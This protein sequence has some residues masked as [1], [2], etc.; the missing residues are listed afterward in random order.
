MSL[1]PMNGQGSYQSAAD[2]IKRMRL[3]ADLLRKQ[4]METPQG[5]M[6]GS[7]GGGTK[8]FGQQPEFYVAPHW[9]EQLAPLA[10]AG[11]SIWGNRQADTA[12]TA[13]DAQAKQEAD[14]AYQ[15]F[16]TMQ[17]QRMALPRTLG[18]GQAGPERSPTMLATRPE[19]GDVQGVQED[20]TKSQPEFQ[21][22][23][24]KYSANLPNGNP[25]LGDLKEKL[26]TKSLEMAGAEYKQQS[27]ES[28]VGQRLAH[29]AST[30]DPAA[31]KRYQYY[32]RLSP[33]Q[34][35]DFDAAN[36]KPEWLNQGNQVQQV[37]RAG[38]VA[39]VAPLPVNL[40]PGEL[41]Q[42]KYLQEKAVNQAQVED[43]AAAQLP[44]LEMKMGALADSNAVFNDAVDLAKQQ[45]EGFGA[46]GVGSQ[47]TK[48][49]GGTPAHNLSQTIKTIEAS[50]GFSALQQ[51]KD[52]S[53]QG[54]AL[55]QVSD[56]E[57]IYLKTLVASV[58]QSQTKEQFLKNLD[59]LKAAKANQAARMRENY[60]R[61]VQQSR[62]KGA[63]LPPDTG[64][65][66]LSTGSMADRNNNPLN[67]T[68]ASTGGMRQFD[69]P[70]AGFDA[71]GAQLDLNA[72]THGLNTVA[73][74]IGRWSPANGVG[75][76]KA[77]TDNYIKF[78]S[79]ALGVGPNDM[80]NI[81]DPAVKQKMMD[82]MAKFE[83]STASSG[84][85]PQAVAANNAVVPS[86]GGTV[87]KKTLPTQAA[88]PKAAPKYRLKPGAN[89]K[90]KSSYEEY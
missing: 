65:Q 8:S 88:A 14:A 55:G 2:R 25:Y 66:V 39:G 74:Q 32:S 84:G 31:V 30:G 81:S 70:Q 45:A 43:K 69:N 72:T 13:N 48:D 9:A 22:E 4:S 5:A 62:A 59:I 82:A 46:T 53:A 83:G 49:I 38:P 77:S 47:L 3:E 73:G 28:I 86:S 90:L 67:L 78:V 42:T 50:M 27:A 23:L 41:P 6:I 10:A 44:A 18:E 79:E 76:S 87:L 40:K 26:L 7:G 58:A 24:S 17:G 15:G 16:P 36:Y 20:Y 71:A 21:N 61:I 64:S 34:K 63:V 51:M 68:S 54:S 29:A 12:E 85:L 37:N 35:L 89:P 11:A 1:L 52:S 80:I 57:M 56:Q 75:N 19:A 33:E 60:D